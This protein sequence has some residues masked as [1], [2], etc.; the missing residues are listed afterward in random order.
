MAKKKDVEITA[1]N[2]QTALF[3]I[4]G[5]T[6]MVMNAFSRRQID[7]M[8]KDHELGDEGKKKAGKKKKPPKDFKKMYEEAKHKSAQGW[9]GIPAVAF[10]HAMVKACSIVGFPM[11]QAKMGIFIEADGFD[12]VDGT[13]LV[14]I[15][16][17]VPKHVEHIVRVGTG[18]NKV[19]DIRARPMWDPGWETTLTVVYD[20]D[21]IKPE[22]MANL[23]ARAGRQVGIMEGRP[24]SDKSV[25]MGWGCFELAPKRGRKKA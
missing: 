7:G 16:K 25:G 12:K 11:T 21:M 6:P 2:F 5:T 23:L 22:M 19:P 4:R 8:R 1:P 18:F 24:S 10:R 20:A 14:K 17:G 15:T 3:K 13:P 9:C